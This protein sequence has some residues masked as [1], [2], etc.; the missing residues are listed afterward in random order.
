MK[1][2]KSALACVFGLIATAANAQYFAGQ[3]VNMIVNYTAG[4]PTDIE[5]RMVAEYLP[6]HLKGVR[7]VVVRN[8][9]GGGGNIGVNQLAASNDKYAIG[10]FTWDPVDQIVENKTLRVKY[11]D[12]KFVAGFQ[13]VVLTYAR[14]DT[15]PGLAKSADIVKSPLVRVGALSPSNHLTTRMRLAFDLLGVNYEV[16]PG[17]RGLRDIEFAVQQGD[18]N[19]SGTSLPAWYA[20][21]KPN[22]A[23]AGIVMPLFQFDSDL[24]NGKLGRSPEFPDVPS[25]LEVYKD[26]KGANA[27]PGGQRWQSMLLLG[28][29][30]DAMYRTVFMAPGAPPEAVQEMRAAF[31]GLAEDPDFIAHYDRIVKTKPRILVGKKGE[32]IIGE[33]GRISPTQLTFMRSYVE[34][35]K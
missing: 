14:K 33:L 12:L 30:M 18:I 11:N 20:T 10:F 6:K 16:I 28:R 21:V 7:S 32:E 34:T 29:I 3:D 26:A 13:Q 19:I 27:M 9:G 23:D 31:E 24:G 1:F 17:Y 22:M 15:K 35:A 25:F 8:V 5:A 2:I 4:G